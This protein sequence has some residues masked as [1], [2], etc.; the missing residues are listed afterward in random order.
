MFHSGEDLPG[1][2][3]HRSGN[4]TDVASFGLSERLHELS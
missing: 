2:S 4:T 3:L 1:F